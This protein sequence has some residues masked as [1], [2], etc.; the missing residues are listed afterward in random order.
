MTN[1]HDILYWVQKDN[2]LGGGTSSGDPQSARWE[3]P[4]NGWGGPV[5]PV[6]STSLQNPVV[7][8][9]QP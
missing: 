1:G 8:E 2:P 3:Y 5:A 4:I 6:A 7:P 9:V